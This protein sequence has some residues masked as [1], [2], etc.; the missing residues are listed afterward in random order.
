MLR[1]AGCFH[2]HFG[3]Q[4]A[5][6]RVVALGNF[7]DPRRPAFALELLG[8]LTRV[9]DGVGTLCTGGARDAFDEGVDLLG[10][11]A[12]GV[13]GAGIDGK[14]QDEEGSDLSDLPQEKSA[15]TDQAAQADL[16]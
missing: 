8:A 1:D 2:A 10:C 16:P 15:V 12:A 14:D 13:E 5:H 3:S 9:E 11:I 4:F 6:A 7:H